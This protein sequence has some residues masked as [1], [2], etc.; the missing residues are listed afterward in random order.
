MGG[1]ADFFQAVSRGDSARVAELIRADPGLLR[2]TAEHGKTALHLAAETDRLDVARVLVDAGADIEAK[3]PWGASPLDWAATLGSARVAEF[4]LSRGADGFTLMTAAALGKRRE[5][6]SIV[7]SGV[8][9]SLHRRRAAPA[10]PDDYWPRDTAHIRGDVLSDA[11]YSAARNGHAPVVEYLL[12]RGADVDAKGVFGATALHW[13]AFNGHRATV[14]L[15]MA[16]G[17]NLSVKDARF[18]ATA[19]GWAAEAGHAAIVEMLSRRGSISR[20]ELVAQVRA[21]GVVPGSIL[22][23]HTSFSKV[24]P[25][26]GGPRGLIEALRSALGPEGTLVMPSLTDQDDDP[27]DPRSSPCAGMGIVADTFWRMPGVLRTDNPHAFAAIGPRA[28]EITAPQPVDIPHGVESPVGR[29]R[30]FDGYVLLL[31]VGHDADTTIHL[32]ENIAGVRYHKAAHATVMS[33]GQAKRYDYGEVDH[34][35]AN[36]SLL[37]DWLDTDDG[38]CRQG[39]GI[40]GHAEARLARSRDI[41]EAA[42]K[43]LRENETVFLHPPGVCG[44]CD[45]ARA[46]LPR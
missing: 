2:V 26:E 7:E 21:L 31:G 35:C 37:D 24:G 30:D 13:A 45:Q 20:R 16:R 4:L 39:R 12:S 9:L 11:L 41:V 43:R 29:V 18:D 42:L 36:F 14:D 5:V 23:V 22:I 27:F 28:V 34:C 15:L 44:E 40:V 1:I 38:Q 33:G 10:A 3:T 32:A 19:E 46:S 6:E 25:V 17:A 8:D